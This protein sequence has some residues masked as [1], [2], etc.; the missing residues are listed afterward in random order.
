ME[1]ARPLSRAST[2][3]SDGCGGS[4]TSRPWLK[5]ARFWRAFSTET[6]KI[7]LGGGLKTRREWHEKNTGVMSENLAGCLVAGISGCRGAY[8]KI[9][10]GS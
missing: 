7:W 6:K 8:G 3:I 4:A 2:F 9:G 1:R 10:K 5:G